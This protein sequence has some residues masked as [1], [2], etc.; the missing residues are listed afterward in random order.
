MAAA[1]AGRQVEGE[2]LRLRAEVGTAVR[3]V[4][5]AFR[6]AEL[7]AGIRE[8]SGEELRLAQERFRLGL[9]SSIEVV[10]AQAN[11][12]QAERDEISAVYEFHISF[13]ALESLVGTP[14]R[15]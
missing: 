2:E 6:I 9:A 4:E 1:N 8:N 7:Q 11:L 10:D 14:L 5:T 15:D 13:A 12:S 3:A